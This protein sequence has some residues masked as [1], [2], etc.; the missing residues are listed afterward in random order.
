MEK[1]I[2]KFLFF[3]FLI[4]IGIALGYKWRMVQLD[5][6]PTQKGIFVPLGRGEPEITWGQITQNG[7]ITQRFIARDARGRIGF[8]L[9][10]A[11]PFEVWA[12][13]R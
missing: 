4:L 11:P 2:R 13:E 8:L 6:H 9:R 5:N 1:K 7:V 12:E 10:A 3:A